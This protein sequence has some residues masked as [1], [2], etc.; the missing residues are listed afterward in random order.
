MLTIACVQMY[1]YWLV[2]AATRETLTPPANSKARAVMETKDAAGG[3]GKNKLRRQM[4]RN[5]NSHVPGRRPKL[6]KKIILAGIWFFNVFSFGRSWIKK[7]GWIYFRQDGDLN[8][9]PCSGVK[10]A[11]YQ[12]NCGRT[13]VSNQR[14]GKALG[15]LEGVK[16]R[17]KWW[18]KDVMVSIPLAAPRAVACCHRNCVIFSP[19]IG[20]KKS[21][22]KTAQVALPRLELMLEHMHP[23]NVAG[24][25]DKNRTLSSVQQNGSVGVRCPCMHDYTAKMY[26]F[27]L[28]VEASAGANVRTAVNEMS[29]RWR[30]FVTVC[31]VP[32]QMTQSFKF[33][34]RGIKWL[35]FIFRG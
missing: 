14:N 15:R 29:P 35:N 8:V 7:T 4:N 16:V 18:V 24:A 9:P 12:V 2:A 10:W 27:W 20:L 17:A 25:E 11:S 34:R 22:T 13:L 26:R 32:H 31:R 1:K 5:R 30:P 6:W 33:S 23:A 28:H 19:L 21:Q 3:G